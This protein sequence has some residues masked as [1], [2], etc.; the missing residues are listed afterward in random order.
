MP[1]RSL[2]PL[3]LAVS[4]FLTVLLAS[5]A[6]AQEPLISGH[7]VG[8]TD[9]DTI[10]VLSADQ[11]F[12]IRIAFIDSPEMH[13]AFGYRAKQAMSELVF[14]REVELRVHTT[15]RYG[16]LVC[17]VFVEGKD[18][19]LE[20]IKQ[21]LAWAYEHYLP[22][23]PAEAQ[24]NYKAAEATARDNRLGLWA[25][26]DPQPPWE[27]RRLQRAARLQLATAG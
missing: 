27:F 11:H 7:V 18:A 6:L 26:A 14:G 2:A 15:D 3:R 23:A 10:K 25:D 5:V 4:A 17:L 8:V 13:Q 24:Q 1:R 16:R 19:G 9:G 20:L 22:E 12:R 21:G